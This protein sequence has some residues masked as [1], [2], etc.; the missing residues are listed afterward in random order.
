MLHLTSNCNGLLDGSPRSIYE[1]LGA[2]E[3][4]IEISSFSK[5]IGF[6]GIRLGWIVLKLVGLACL[7][8]N[9]RKAI[10]SVVDY[11]MENVDVL[12]NTFASM[13]LK[14]YGGLNAPYVWDVN[15]IS[16]QFPDRRFDS[17][18]TSKSASSSMDHE[19]KY[20]L[21]DADRKGG[22]LKE[23]VIFDRSGFT[24]D[25]NSNVRGKQLIAFVN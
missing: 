12:L 8:S 22:E 19:K 6:T 11:Y 25:G 15:S 13:G 4:V 18:T 23:N 16:R 21:D 10:Y 17:S 9:G 5:I 20:T 2:K 3:V 24:G 1:I 7:S 14:A